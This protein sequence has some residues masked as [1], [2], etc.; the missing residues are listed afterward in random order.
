MMKQAEIFAEISSVSTTTGET[1]LA[2]AQELA[3]VASSGESLSSS[4]INETN[5]KNILEKYGHH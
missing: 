4:L 2:I 3:E 1:S 5:L